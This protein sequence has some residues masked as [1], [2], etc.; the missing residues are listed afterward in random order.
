MAW[1][2][3]G[4]LEWQRIGLAKP[5]AVIN[6]TAAYI[7][8]ED[9][10]KIWIGERCAFGDYAQDLLD[11]YHDYQT[12]CLEHREP[13]LGR[14]QWKKAFLVATKAEGVFESVNSYSRRATFERV[15]LR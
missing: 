9:K 6:A 3:E 1:F 2:V 10:L 7:A 14:R 4:C 8:D 13:Q 12:W 11:L 15:G 5:E